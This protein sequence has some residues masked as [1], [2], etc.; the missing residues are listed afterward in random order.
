MEAAAPPPA[1]VLA[2]LRRW[3]DDVAR[4]LVARDRQPEC[5]PLPPGEYGDA[6]AVAELA[7]ELLRLADAGAAALAEPDP[8]LDEERTVMAGHYAAEPIARPYRPSDP[9]PLRDG[10]LV[11]ALMRPPFWEGS[12]PPRGAWCSCCGRSNPQAGGRWWRPRHPRMDGT[13]AGPGWRCWT[14]HPPPPGCETEEIR[15]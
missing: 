15:T 9:D 7:R 5:G 13:G 14:C 11:G 3:R 12:A 10:L 6:E 1:D 2:D 8:A 4:L